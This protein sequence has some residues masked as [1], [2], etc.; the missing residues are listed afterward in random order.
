MIPESCIR[1][2]HP[3]HEGGRKYRFVLTKRFHY[4]LRGAIAKHPDV[5]FYDA[6]GMRW[7]HIRSGTLYIEKG[8]AW[9]GCSPKYYIGSPPIGKWIGTPD[10]DGSLEAS[11]VHD[12]LFQFSAVAKY[13]F[14]DCNK[15]FLL[16]MQNDNFSLADTYYAAVCKLGR[17]FYGVN[18]TGLKAVYL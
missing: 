15:Q 3:T 5:S 11:L 1:R 18:D 2:L 7:A 17:K 8:Y 16:I 9:N 4:M 6:S 10:F 12:V 13:T 14:E